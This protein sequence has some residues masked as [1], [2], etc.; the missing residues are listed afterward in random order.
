MKSA[1]AEHRVSTSVKSL[2]E[3]AKYLQSDFKKTITDT[4]QQ[5]MSLLE[6]MKKVE[7]EISDK[8]N[9]NVK[10]PEDMATNMKDYT[11]PRTN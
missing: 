10:T 7:V 5:L 11:F 4:K 8:L 1:K 3:K 6:K 9:E 2:L